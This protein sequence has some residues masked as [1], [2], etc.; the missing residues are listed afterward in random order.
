MMGNTDKV[1]LIDTLSAAIACLF[2]DI[3]LLQARLGAQEGVQM[4]SPIFGDTGA[5]WSLSLPR[6]DAD[7]LARLINDMTSGRAMLHFEA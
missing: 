2:G 4:H 7:K 6:D 5:T 1:P 3:A